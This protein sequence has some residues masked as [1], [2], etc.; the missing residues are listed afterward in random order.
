MLQFES[1]DEI[2][3]HAI[4]SEEYA[5]EVYAIL[6][7]KVDDRGMQEILKTFVYEEQQHKAKLQGIKKSRHMEAATGNI[8]SL[9]FADSL[10]P[11]DLTEY[12]SVEGLDYEAVL[13]MA[14]K[15][16]KA[17][18][19]LYADLAA[20]APTPKLQGILLALAE[21]EAKHKL[22]FE[23]EYDNYFRKP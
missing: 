15:A 12:Q 1:A 7:E 10:I 22:T 18:F 19:K 11:R 21:E 4:K 17:A 23:I 5:A 16:E 8:K 9:E 3:D 2:L 13:I 20:A 6:A 14:M